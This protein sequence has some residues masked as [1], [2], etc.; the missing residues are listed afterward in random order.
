TDGH[1]LG[2][3]IVL[4][5]Q[6]VETLLASPDSEPRQLAEVARAIGRLGRT[7]LMPDLERLLDEDL[8]RWRRVRQAHR[9]AP[10]HATIELRSDAAHSWTLQYRQAFA[11]I[12]TDQVVRLMGK[13]LEDGDFG[14]DA[15]CV[16]KAVCDRE[17]NAPRPILAMPWADFSNVKARRT[18]RDAENARLPPSPLA[19][20]IFAAIER[21]MQPGAGENGQRL[22]IM[23]GRIAL[24]MPHGDRRA[25]IDALVALPQ[26]IRAKRELLAALVLDGEIIAA[27]LVLEGVRAWLDDAQEHTWMFR[28]GL[29]EV[30][31]WLELMPFTNRPG[32]TTEGVEWV[33]S[34]LPRPHRMERVVSAL[35]VAPGDEVEEVLKQLVHRY[36][37]LASQHEWVEAIIARGTVS[38]ARILVDLVLDGRFAGARGVTDSWWISDQLAFLARLHPELQVDVLRRYGGIAPH[39]AGQRVIEEMLSKIGDPECVSALARGYASNRKPFDGLIQRALHDVA[40]D[41]RPAAGWVG[42]YDLVPVA[43]AGLRRELFGML[44]GPP[45][46]A[47]LGSACLTAIDELRDAFG[48][49]EFE[50]RHPDVESGRPWPLAAVF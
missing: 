46:E 10:A 23:L 16:L 24:S 12:G 31:G 37:H 33:N 36:P 11:N 2:A 32:A 27:D 48:P 35:G 13:Y 14:F 5:H 8:S 19:D 30:E 41:Q 26:P 20:M 22:A 39:H 4:I 44:E 18:Q 49:A 21:L 6:W 47:A 1:L 43:L 29:W 17:Q 7:E 15:G 28:E 40:L 45:H 42:A 50:P 9:E 25:V 34:A 38:A 3:L